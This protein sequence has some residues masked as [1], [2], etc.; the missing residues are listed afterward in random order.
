MKL[1]VEHMTD[2]ISSTPSRIGISIFCGNT[3]IRNTK[4]IGSVCDADIG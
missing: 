1:F 3:G 4:M 2:F